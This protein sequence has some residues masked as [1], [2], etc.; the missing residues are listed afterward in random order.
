MRQLEKNFGGRDVNGVLEKGHSQ[1][2]K[3]KIHRSWMGEA[4]AGG[5]PRSPGEGG[6]SILKGVRAA[7]GRQEGAAYLEIREEK[8]EKK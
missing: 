5:H 6:T 2:A 1:K 3:R 8:P 4:R 7:G